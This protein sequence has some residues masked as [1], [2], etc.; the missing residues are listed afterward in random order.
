MDHLPPLNSVKA[1]EATAR[2]LSITAA[3]EELCVT[4]GAVS[5]QIKALEEDLD[6]QLL[7]RGHRQLTLTREGTFLYEAAARALNEIRGA[8][9][10]IRRSGRQKHLNIRAYTTFA[11]RWLIPRLS[12]FYLVNPGIQ[13]NLTTSVDE[14]DFRKEDID[15]AIRLG[16]GKWTGVLAH[17]LVENILIPVASPDLLRHTPIHHVSD[18][19]K[20]TLLHSVARPY[21]WEFWLNSAAKNVSIDARSGMSYQSSAMA[22]MAAIGGQ[23]VA[24]A[25]QFLVEEDVVAGRLAAPLVNVVNMREF[26]YYLLVPSHRPESDNMLAFRTWLLSELELK[27]PGTN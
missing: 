26:T 2:H 10:K 3:A 15:G 19:R 11:M 13:V 12:N 5:R 6:L 22:Y 23:G 18:L 7:V 20:H 16:D 14:V 1:F 17:R 21:D 27:S 8:S 4:A 24:I 9:S 25:Q